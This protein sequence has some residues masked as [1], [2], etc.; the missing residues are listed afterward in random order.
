MKPSSLKED[1]NLMAF[2]CNSFDENDSYDILDDSSTGSKFHASCASFG[3]SVRGFFGNAVGALMENMESEIVES[4]TAEE[5][6]RDNAV[7]AEKLQSVRYLMGNEEFKEFKKQMNENGLVTTNAIRQ[8]ISQS[9]GKRASM[10][11]IR[12]KMIRT[13]RSVS[14]DMTQ[15][16]LKTL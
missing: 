15:N 1:Y 11:L 6:L 2:N 9:I 16:Y 8:Q 14:A 13:P 4:P 5:V 12:K 3:S 10:D 7:R